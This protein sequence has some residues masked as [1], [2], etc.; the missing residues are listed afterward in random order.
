MFLLALQRFMNKLLVF[1]R[2]SLLSR[3]HKSKSLTQSDGFEFQYDRIGERITGG[4]IQFWRT[5]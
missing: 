2:Q 5:C 3:R 1:I 4:M